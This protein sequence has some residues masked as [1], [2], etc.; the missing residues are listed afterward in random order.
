MIPQSEWVW[1]PHPG[2]LIV[3]RD[4]RFHLA[5]RVGPF[6]VSTVGE[7][8]P[9]ADVREILAEARGVKLEGRGDQRRG[10]FMGKVGYT[11]I[12][13]GRLYE[14]MVFRAAPAPDY[15]GALGA[16]C[17][18]RQ[19]DGTDLSCQGFNTAAEA[20]AGHLATCQRMAAGDTEDGD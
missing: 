9:D 18:W 16:C 6:L 3:G 2:H 13:C 12:G 4:C 14:T 7:Y 10:D 20:Y 8:L 5:T 1:M 17:P 19:A 11:E 15:E